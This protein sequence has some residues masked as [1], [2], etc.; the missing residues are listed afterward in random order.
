MKNFLFALLLLLPF[1]SHEGNAQDKKLYHRLGGY[2]A[3]AA[4]VDDFVGRLAGD[5]SLGR[6]FKGHSTDSV[7]KIRQHVVDQICEA[8]GGPCYYI[9]RS[10]KASHAGMGISEADWDASVKHLVATLDK[11][12][13]PQAEKDELLSVVSSLKGDIVEMAKK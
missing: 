5:P 7:K 4:V 13:V 2:D 11:F 9:G 1:V 8:S 10:M 6:F 3:I 12:K